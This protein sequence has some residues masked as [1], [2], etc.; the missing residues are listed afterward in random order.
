MQFK[1][2]LHEIIENTGHRYCLFLQNKLK[3]NFTYV[4]THHLIQFIQLLTSYT[5]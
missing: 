1:T 4:K 2:H 3:H 5:V